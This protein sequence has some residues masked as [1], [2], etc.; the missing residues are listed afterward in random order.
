MI[1]AAGARQT[2]AKS[3]KAQDDVMADVS[4]KIEKEASIGGCFLQYDVKIP[5]WTVSIAEELQRKGFKA[6]VV[7]ENCIHIRW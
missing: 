1:T 4:A 6:N 2:L 5:E 3:K 7:S